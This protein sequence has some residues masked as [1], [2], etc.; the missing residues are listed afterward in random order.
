VVL[1]AFLAMV[2][3][4]DPLLLVAHE[5]PD[6]PASPAPRARDALLS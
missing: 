1:D 5:T 4:L 3:D 2:D 6:A